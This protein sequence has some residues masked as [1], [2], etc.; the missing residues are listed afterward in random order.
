MFTFSRKSSGIGIGSGTIIEGGNCGNPRGNRSLYELK[1]RFQDQGGK[2]AFWAHARLECFFRT[3]AGATVGAV[4][5]ED[6]VQPEEG[7]EFLMNKEELFARSATGTVY[8]HWS[9][10]LSPRHCGK[11]NP[12]KP[13]VSC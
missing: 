5:L 11:W 7:R 2:L 13:V 4:S 6:R 8:C 9:T 10:G 12:R 1:E 3:N